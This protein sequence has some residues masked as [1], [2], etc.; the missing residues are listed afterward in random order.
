MTTRVCE[1][2][3][4]RGYGLAED[5]CI[6]CALDAAR[7]RIAVLE[8][9]VGTPDTRCITTPDG[10]CVGDGCMHDA[11]SP[12][13]AL[14]DSAIKAID[15]ALS[16][17]APT[18]DRGCVCGHWRSV[19]K[20]VDGVLKCTA[21]GCA[22]GPGCIHDGFVAADGTVQSDDAPTE[23]RSDPFPWCSHPGCRIVATTSYRLSREPDRWQPW[24]EDHDPGAPD[25]VLGGLERKPTEDRPLPCDCDY[26]ARVAAT[27]SQPDHETEAS[28]RIDLLQSR[29]E[30]SEARDRIAELP[31]GAKAEAPNC[32]RCGCPTE[33]HRF[34]EIERG[35]E[36]AE[37]RA[38]AEAAEKVL[39]ELAPKQG[40][41]P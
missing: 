12:P 27:P 3:R 30:L 11:A 37:A 13:D 22:C 1:E 8:T 17:P 5:A 4:L 2:H 39:R 28:L 29:N 24:C 20:R 10:G 19:H 14:S 9:E 21:S 15:K 23:D 34:L 7:A 35:C 18:E 16:L 40:D 31:T 41:I 6:G 33:V 26:W 32:S 36:I 38:R 25:H